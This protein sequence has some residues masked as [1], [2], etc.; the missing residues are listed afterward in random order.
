M[1]ILRI[2]AMIGIVTI[3]ILVSVQNAWATRTRTIAASQSPDSVSKWE[4][5]MAR[6]LARVPEDVTVFGY[7]ADWD[8]PNAQYDMID[9][10]QEYVLTQYALA[11]RMVQP[12]LEHEWIIGNF[13]TPDFEKWLD[14]NLSS[15]EMTDMGFGIYLIHRTSP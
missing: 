13:I 4:D 9:Q 7:V 2:V 10:D 6:V 5:R 14:Q 11:P 1:K 3:A 15:Y 8:L 12:G